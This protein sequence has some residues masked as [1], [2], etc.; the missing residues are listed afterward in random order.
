[1]RRFFGSKKEEVAAPTLD[2]ASGSIGTRVD[3]LDEKI[4]KLDAELRGHKEKLK[5][6]KGPSKTTLTKRAMEVLKRKRMYETQRDQLSGQQFNIEQAGFA[7]ESAK[8]TVVTVAAMKVSV[9]KKGFI[10]R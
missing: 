7:I 6:A 10:K 4:K 2:Q 8:D 3:A 5:T 1:M 9:S